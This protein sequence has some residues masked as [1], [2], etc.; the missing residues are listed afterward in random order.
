MLQMETP[1]HNELILCACEFL[2]VDEFWIE[3]VGIKLPLCRYR[4]RSDV[5]PL[6][7]IPEFQMV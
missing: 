2:N 5:N 1:V 4:L 6:Y 3:G 7:S